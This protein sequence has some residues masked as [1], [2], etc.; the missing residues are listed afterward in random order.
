MDEFLFGYDEHFDYVGMEEEN[1][2]PSDLPKLKLCPEFD[3]LDFK[4]TSPKVKQLVFWWSI[5]ILAL[6]FG[7]LLIMLLYI[8]TR[9]TRFYKANWLTKIQ[10]VLLIVISLASMSVLT[11]CIY[12]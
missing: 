12:T 11:I 7:L 8:C 6:Y 1:F 2:H 9:A 4:S 5:P 3:Q 10:F